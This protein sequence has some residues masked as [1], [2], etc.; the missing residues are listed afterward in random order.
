V[1]TPGEYTKYKK[2]F[3]T[4]LLLV[5]GDSRRLTVWNVIMQSGCCYHSHGLWCVT[6]PWQWWCL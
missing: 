1:L 3:A 6:T 2:S 5:A 4:F